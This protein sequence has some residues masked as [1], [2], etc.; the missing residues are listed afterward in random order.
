MLLTPFTA[1]AALL[2]L[3]G[4]AKVTAPE[5]TVSALAYARLPA[6]D[7][8]V[9]LIGV[10]ELGLGLTAIGAPSRALA[11]GI[12]GAYAGFTVVTVS[13]LRAGDQAR[14]GCF[15]ARSSAAHPIHLVL[16]L[17]AVAVAVGTAVSPV[18]S[19]MVAAVVADPASGVLL[20]GSAAAVTA[21]AHQA[22]VAVPALWGA[23]TAPLP[24]EPSA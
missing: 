6:R 5:T 3:A 24:R 10:L 20:A 9:R 23:W 12:A 2:V 1:V 21:L 22:Y 15:G 4:A 19:G 8:L 7:S 16:N 11:V 17:V 13:L 14:C 18:G